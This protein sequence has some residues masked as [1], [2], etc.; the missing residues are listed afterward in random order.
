MFQKFRITNFKYSDDVMAFDKMVIFF[1][2]HSNKLIQQFMRRLSPG[3][4]RHSFCFDSVQ[5][6]YS[7]NSGHDNKGKCRKAN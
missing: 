4:F 3:K 1:I 7:S 6:F 5:H 2:T